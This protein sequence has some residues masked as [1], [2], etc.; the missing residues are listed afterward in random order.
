MLLA[1]IFDFIRVS[2][3]Y[4][5]NER[6]L[7]LCNFNEDIMRGRILIVF[8]S[9]VIVSCSKDGLRT[10]RGIDYSYGRDLKHEK[11][12][13]GDRLENPYTTENMTKAFVSLYPTKADRVDIKTTNL[14]VRFLP[15]DDQEYDLLKSLGVQLVDHPM[16]YDI[17]VDG[18]WYHDPAIPDGEFTWQYAV[19][20]HDF[21]FPDVKY[22]LIDECYISENDS[23]TRTYDDGIDWQAV[24]R[25]A[26]LI[27]GN[28]DR[29]APETVKAGTKVT[30]SGRI[31]I[32]DDGAN[33]GKPFGVA[34]VRISCN[35][36]VKFDSAVTDRDGYYSMSKEFASDLRY[37]LVFE[38]EK[39][40]SIG[41]N[42]VLL[43]AS[44]STLGKSSPE[45]VNMTVTKDSESKLFKRCVVN[46]AVYD[47]ISRC[48]RDDMNITPPPSGMRIW[49]FHNLKASS[50]VMMRHGAVIESDL[51]SRFLGSFASLLEI[52]LPDITLGLGDKNDYKS[53]Y[54]VTCHELAHAS[55]FV[56]AGISYWNRY[57]KYIMASYVRDGEKTY[58]DGESEDAGVCAV[59][60]MW[61]YY[62]E[63]RMYKDR[64]GGSFP[65][66]GTS[67]WFYPQIFRYLDERGF[68]V[69]E[70]FSVLDESV[71]SRSDLK[72]ALI[73]AFP[74]RHAIIE[75]VFSRY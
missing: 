8:M 10:E 73:N 14:Y 59:G 1:A 13:L 41:F 3:C 38:N 61:A 33:G 18:D 29:L 70:I 47:Y 42:L 52:F 45:G 36:F 44:V 4:A 64:Y 43:P 21:V 7:C 5:D 74:S 26:Y 39:G 67:F 66:F 12:V 40:F 6:Q 71:D 15:S 63:S 9:A 72:A 2:F 25:E 58:G 32:V 28:G 57:I 19:L 16:D 23:G 68:K 56:E 55:H 60:E 62:L 17:L 54:S 22:E 69:G 51:I 11:I 50:A 20:P 35:S 65:S 24:E 48:S 49:L 31:T 27:T 46:N 53:I 37:R 34:G 30:P 75:Q